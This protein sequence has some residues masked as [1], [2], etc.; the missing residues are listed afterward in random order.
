MQPLIN[1]GSRDN[2]ITAIVPV[3]SEDEYGE[4]TVVNIQSFNFWASVKELKSDVDVIAGKR[5]TNRVLEITCD[6]RD[7]TDLTELYYITVDGNPEQFQVDDIYENKWKF[8][9][10][11]IVKYKD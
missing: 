11:V 9:S 7:I 5:R 2:Y 3:T 6:T 10:T 4:L 8:I 1:I